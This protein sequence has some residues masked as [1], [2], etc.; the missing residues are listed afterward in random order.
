[1]KCRVTSSYNPAVG[2]L[3]KELTLWTANEMQKI[4]RDMDKKFRKQRAR[5]FATQGAESGALWPALSPEYAKQKKRKY[6]GRKIMQR[7]GTLRK[8]LANKG[9]QHVAT[10]RSGKAPSVTLGT[11]NVVAAYH[12]RPK[13]G[14]RNPLY[15]TRMPDRDVMLHTASQIA[16]L[17]RQ[18]DPAW[19]AKLKRCLRLMIAGQRTM[20]R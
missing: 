5:V 16:E 1:M 17:K 18:F 12:A 8:S 19:K 15:N 3:P 13:P 2:K 10:Y 6:P 4:A 11:E 20:K 7:K 9:G 14:L